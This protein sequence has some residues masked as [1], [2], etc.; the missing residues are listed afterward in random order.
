MKLKFN[1]VAVDYDDHYL[2]RNKSLVMFVVE[3]H[4]DKVVKA[5]IV[6]REALESQYKAVRAGWPM[7]SHAVLIGQVSISGEYLGPVDPDEL[8]KKL[9]ME[10][11]PNMSKHGPN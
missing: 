5:F 8:K 7:H 9:D 4:K 10:V 11:P 1:V 6:E 2:K 3:R